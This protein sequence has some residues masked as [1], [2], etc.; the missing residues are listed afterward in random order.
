MFSLIWFR[1]WG[2]GFRPE[3]FPRGFWGFG[4]WDILGLGFR[5]V[6]VELG[7]EGFPWFRSLAV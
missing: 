3:C 6:G 1:V 5:A 7:V 2:L 4:F